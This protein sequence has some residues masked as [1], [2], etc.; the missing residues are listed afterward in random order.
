MTKRFWF[1]PIY[2]LVLLALVLAGAEYIASYSAPSWPARDL[3]PVPVN[4]LALNVK[5]VLGDTPD[6]IPTYNDWAIRDRP[7]SI[8][9]GRPV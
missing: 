4:A 7:R 3:R 9:R 6:L 8:A 2:G 1:W 5:A